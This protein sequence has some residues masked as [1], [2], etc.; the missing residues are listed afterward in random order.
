MPGDIAARLLPAADAVLGHAHANLTA[1]AA[2]P[3]I[4]PHCRPHRYPL[5]PNPYTIPT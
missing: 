1:N 2:A 3:D 5:S 4:P